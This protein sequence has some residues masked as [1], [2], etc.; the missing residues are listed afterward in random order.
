MRGPLESD[1]NAPPKPGKVLT[2][3]G[4]EK[5][6]ELELAQ[7]NKE[8]NAVGTY[9]KNHAGSSIA[10]YL[11]NSVEFLVTFFGMSVE[12]MPIIPLIYGF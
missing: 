7:L 2:I 6:I 1:E 8:I 10:I 5:V 9:L 4:K 3:L 11:P 12:T